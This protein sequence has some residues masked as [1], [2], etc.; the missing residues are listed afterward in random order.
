[1]RDLGEAFR[2][3][4]TV[5][6]PALLI[7]GSLDGRTPASNAEELLPGFPN[8]R[9]L[10]VRN[11]GHGDDLLVATPELGKDDRA[12]S[13]SSLDDQFIELFLEKSIEDVDLFESLEAAIEHHK[14]LF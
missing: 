4:L 8:G 1:V 13:R 3:P 10:V 6:V 12:V 7:S 11:G 2:G 14:S 9:H 5:D